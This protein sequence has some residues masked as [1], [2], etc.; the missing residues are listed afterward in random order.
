[1]AYQQDSNNDLGLNLTGR[2]LRVYWYL[3]QNKGPHG[4]LEVQR[5]TKLSSASLAEYHLKKLV[6]MGLVEKNVHREY[7]ICRTVQIGVMRFYTMYRSNMIP[8][9]LL[10]ISFYVTM[11][12]AT[13][14]FFSNLSLSSAFLITAVIA[15]GIITSL[16]ESIILLRSTPN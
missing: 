12:F 16:V 13:M 9:F 2:T 3:V 8:R 1:M 4:R 14:A 5:G 7:A 10:Y 6:G 15:F 11:L